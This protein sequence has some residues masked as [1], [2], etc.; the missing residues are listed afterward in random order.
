[1]KYN[2]KCGYKI[3]GV[4]RKQRFRRGKYNDEILIA[5]FKENWLPIWKKYQNTGKVR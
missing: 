5:V 3:E 4:R 1:M 2:L